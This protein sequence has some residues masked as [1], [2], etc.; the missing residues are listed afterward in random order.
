VVASTVI[1]AARALVAANGGTIAPKDAPFIHSV[2]SQNFVT[3]K[4]AAVVA[5]ILSNYREQLSGLGFEY[6]ALVVPAGIVRYGKPGE[7]PKRAKVE[8]IRRDVEAARP[9]LPPLVANAPLSAW[10][11][12]TEQ[13]LSWFPAGFTPRPQQQYAIEKIN[14]AFAAGKRVVVLESPTGAGKSFNCMTFARAVK[15]SGGATHF[16]TIQKTLQDQYTRDFP[17]P[18]VEVLKGRANYACT[19]P[20]SDGADAANGVCKR[21]KKG[22]LGECV[23]DEAK[24]YAQDLGISPVR[25]AIALALPAACHLC[26]YWNQ[27]QKCHDSAI[28]LFNFSS[29]LFQVRM[30]RF[31]KRNLMVVD[32]GHNIEAQLMNFVSMELTEW[33]LSLVGVRITGDIRTKEQFVEWLRGTDIVQRIQ[34]KLRGDEDEDTDEGNTDLQKTEQDA[35]EDLLMKIENFLR[36]LERTDWILETVEYED[37]RGAPTKKIVAR[38][39]YVRDFADDLLFRH[40]QRVLVMSA[41]ILD[42]GV[43]ADNLGI[44]REQIAHVETP[45]D[46]P[47]EHRPIY[48]DYAG[49]MGRKYFARKENPK[50]PTE[51]KFVA[52][53]QT[54][55]ERHE[56]QRGIIHCHSFQ[57]S[58]VLAHHVASKRFLFQDG[59]KDK[60]EMLAAHAKRE[61]SVIV[62]PAMHEGLDLKDGLSRFQ[63]IAKIPW[64]SLGDRVVKE[65]QSRDDRWYGWLTA[66]KLVQSY[67]R[68]VRSVKDWAMTYILDTGF[69]AFYHTHG[70]MLPEWFRSALRRG[71]P[72]ESQVLR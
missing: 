15:A 20:D 12:T 6:T 37:R 62:A 67:G 29:F 34:K 46:F 1:D 31:S 55:L 30:G 39:L 17:A 64:P 44:P 45:C 27:L 41:T 71:A 33:A 26:P 72:L 43:W 61:D 51:P 57:L 53:I 47:V 14:E 49:N 56:G 70:M 21:N 60:A 25:A 36:Y 28:T 59:F 8:D 50:D 40:A 66:L 52:K 11:I 3:P 69:E 9:K 23:T 63:V 58:E 48:K 54:I 7:E 42:V 4:Q 10:P 2:L 68:S 18:E 38:P 65:R 19:H 5:R 16:L 24:S 22:I 32:E 35:L 13:A